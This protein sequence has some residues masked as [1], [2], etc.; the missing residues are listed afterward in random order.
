MEM[1]LREEWHRYRT[2]CARAGVDA[3]LWTGDADAA[4][5]A[6]QELIADMRATFVCEN[7]VDHGAVDHDDAVQRQLDD[8]EEA[9][10][11][12]TDKL[13]DTHFG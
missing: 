4:V 6:E 7:N 13:L 3:E 5:H 12:A 9:E 1:W 2:E 8:Y 11:I 10:R